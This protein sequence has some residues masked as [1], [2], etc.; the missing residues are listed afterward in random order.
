MEII[1]RNQEPVSYTHLDVYKRQ[2]YTQYRYALGMINRYLKQLGRL[3]HIDLPLTTYVA[4]HSW[5]TIAKNEV[6]PSRIT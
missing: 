4:R 1:R 5:A 6:V 2:V 3:L